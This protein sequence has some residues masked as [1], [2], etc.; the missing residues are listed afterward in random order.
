[1]KPN[2]ISRTSDLGTHRSIWKDSE[3]VRARPLATQSFYTS[4]T[5]TIVTRPTNI[6]N[7][8]PLS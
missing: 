3:M 2:C 4:G 7:A 1:M 6:F 5:G 8:I